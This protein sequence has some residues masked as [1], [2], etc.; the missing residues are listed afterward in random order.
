MV[1]ERVEGKRGK[2]VQGGFVEQGEGQRMGE[3]RF[4]WA[5]EE[6]AEDG[7]VR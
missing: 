5:K 1:A 6:K 2:S 3:H 4:K 7:G